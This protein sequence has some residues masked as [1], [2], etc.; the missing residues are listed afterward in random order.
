MNKKYDLISLGEVMM[1]LTG[2]R[3]E[4]L[5]CGN[6]FSRGAG[7]SELSVAAGAS[8]LGLRTAFLTK[9]PENDLGFYIKNCILSSGVSTEYLAFD[10]LPDARLGTYFYEFGA[11]PRKPKVVYDRAA[12]SV[13]RLSVADIP[14]ELFS[15]TR[16]FHTSGITLARSPQLRDTAIELIHRFKRGGT[17]ISFDVNFRANL[18]TGE[19]AR[20]VI[21]PLLPEIDYFFCSEDTARL[22]F[23]KEGDL[24]T[25]M[26]SFAEEYPM[27]IVASTHRI[28]HSPTLHTFGSVIYEK[29]TDRFYE[30]EPYRNIEV[31]DRLGSGDAYLSGALYG[32]LSEQGNCQR[33][34]EFGNA[35]SAVKNTFFGDLPTS[36]RAE[37]EHIIRDH[38]ADWNSE[39]DR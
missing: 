5:V 11:V 17:K 35:A 7:G 38:Q 32:L 26:K 28:V 27:S 4:R 30:E 15:N 8:L 37:L 12:A 21:T 34:L 23:H 16:C 29:A 13:N 2:P 39:M 22:T 24:H 10:S 14:D 18:W 3:D 1:R 33:A 36:N 19:E 25:I 9:L 31:I 20:E 6:S